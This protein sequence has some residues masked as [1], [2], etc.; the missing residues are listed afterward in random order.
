M[1]KDS[2]SD[3]VCFAYGSEIRSLFRHTLGKQNAIVNHSSN[4]LNGVFVHFGSHPS[5]QVSQ[6]LCSLVS[7]QVLLRFPALALC[8]VNLYNA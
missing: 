3:K 7:T 2:Q 4:S 5:N 1:M 6:Y 8:A